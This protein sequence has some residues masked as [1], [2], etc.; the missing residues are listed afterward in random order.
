MARTLPI[1]TDALDELPLL[2]PKL[3]RRG[4]NEFNEFDPNDAV[5]TP[6]SLAA[7]AAE[8]IRP[9]DLTFVPPEAFQKPDVAAEITELRFHFFESYRQDM[10]NTTRNRRQNI[11]AGFPP[12]SATSVR[13]DCSKATAQ[14]FR[15]VLR[16]LNLK[17]V[18]CRKDWTAVP[19]SPEFKPSRGCNPWAH[20]YGPPRTP[21]CQDLQAT[22]TC[23]SSPSS[24]K[25]TSPKNTS[26]MKNSKSAPVIGL[27]PPTTAGSDAPPSPTMGDTT[28]SWWSMGAS[29]WRSEVSESNLATSIQQLRTAPGI[30]WRET[31]NARRVEDTFGSTREIEVKT[32]KSRRYDQDRLTKKRLDAAVANFK[33]LEFDQRRISRFREIREYMSPPTVRSSKFFEKLARVKSVNCKRLDEHEAVMRDDFVK[34]MSKQREIERFVDEDRFHTRMQ[35]AQ[36]TIEDRLRWRYN[37]AVV[38]NE[39]D[40]DKAGMEEDFR[41]KTTQVEQSG[42]T[43]EDNDFLRREVMNLRET[44]RLFEDCRYRRK[45]EYEKELWRFTIEDRGEKRLEDTGGHIEIPPWSLS[46]SRIAV[47]NRDDFMKNRGFSMPMS[48]PSS[49][50]SSPMARNKARPD[51][52]PNVEDVEV[53]DKEDV[54]WMHRVASPKLK[55]LG[56]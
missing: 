56:M 41:R 32:L 13:E 54:N 6:R 44:F 36:M 52:L 49:M 24:I 43:T 30:D 23:P 25:P 31:E 19:R 16:S 51:A 47:R 12:P 53:L 22:M 29:S 38:E 18:P 35:F 3:R 2:S 45:E 55:P 50:P 46:A 27:T 11:I 39:R 34:R 1:E 42:K 48:P 33:A 9:Q 20:S 28:S 10:L 40:D 4:V 8:G 14:F 37:Y 26:S 5:E 17:I 7:C 15:E 21:V